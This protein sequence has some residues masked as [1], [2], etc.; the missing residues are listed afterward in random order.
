MKTHQNIWKRDTNI[1]KF[2][3]RDKIIWKRDLYAVFEVLNIFYI[4]RCDEV[5]FSKYFIKTSVRSRNTILSFILCNLFDVRISFS[6]LSKIYF[7][8][9]ELAR[10]NI[11]WTVRIGQPK[12]ILD[13]QNCQILKFWS[14][15]RILIL[16]GTS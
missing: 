5:L 15:S 4:R 2:S 3:K 9:S 12:Y 10:Q 16:D 6:W 11:F 1:I 14:R 13:S 7:G 8:Q